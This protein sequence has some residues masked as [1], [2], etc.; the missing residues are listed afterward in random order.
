MWANGPCYGSSEAARNLH[1]GGPQAV[2][3]DGPKGP[4]KAVGGRWQTEETDDG[5]TAVGGTP[6]TVFLG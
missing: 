3:R 2:E 6:S 1:H 4:E 5:A